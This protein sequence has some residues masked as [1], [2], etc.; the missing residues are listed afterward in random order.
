M[1]KQLQNKTYWYFIIYRYIDSKLSDLTDNLKM[2]N[3]WKE[4][5]TDQNV[6]LFVLKIID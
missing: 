4:K 2:E 1:V 3:V 6:N 5:K